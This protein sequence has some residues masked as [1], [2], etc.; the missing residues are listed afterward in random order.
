MKKDLLTKDQ[1]EIEVLKDE[2]ESLKE[3]IKELQYELDNIPTWTLV[4]YEYDKNEEKT[5]PMMNILKMGSGL[6]YDYFNSHSI[7][8]IKL[9]PYI[10]NFYRIKYNEF[11]RDGRKVGVLDETVLN[12]F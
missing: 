5:D 7:V 4:R 6:E 8:F 12:E 10:S 3:T 11:R 9:I 2:V 1:V